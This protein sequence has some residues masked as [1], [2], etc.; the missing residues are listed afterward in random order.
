MR[1]KVK[2]FSLDRGYGFIT[3]EQSKDHYFSVRDVRGSDLPAACDQVQ[4]LSQDT[5][6]GPRA[7]GVQLISRSTENRRVDDRVTCGYCGKKM[8][9][10][11]ISHQGQ[12]ERSVCPFCAGTY[13][14]FPTPRWVWLV[15][16]IF[17]IL[18][19]TSC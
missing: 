3:D 16:G 17:A 18:F 4:F 7:S 19:L 2:W 14:S 10:R 13:R 1:G 5:N 9:P 15:L 11:I 6:R 12:V 8:V